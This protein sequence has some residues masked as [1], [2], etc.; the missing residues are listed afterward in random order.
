MKKYLAATIAL[1][2]IQ[3]VF[4]TEYNFQQSLDA[5]SLSRLLIDVPVGEIV[6]SEA[7]G[8]EVAMNITLKGDECKGNDGAE[9]EVK[10]RINKER[11]KISFDLDDC[12]VKAALSVPTFM[13]I[14]IDMGV[15]SLKGAVLNTIYGD[16]GVGEVNLDIPSKA[17][18]RVAVEAG[19]GDADIL[20]SEGQ[21]EKTSRF[22]INQSIVWQGDGQHNANIQVGVGNIH[23][24]E[25]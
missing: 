18:Q 19:V 25:L 20:L 23:I 8:N 16:I 13:E 11:I 2:S 5:E 10:A 22:F 21:I 14:D 17:F 9:P 4:A 3:P 12:T 1:L 6:L 24:R 7:T 15:G